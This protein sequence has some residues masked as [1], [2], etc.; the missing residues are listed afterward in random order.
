MYTADHIFLMSVHMLLGVSLLL[1][2]FA[3]RIWSV[4]KDTTIAVYCIYLVVCFIMALV[5]ILNA[6]M[7]VPGSDIMENTWSDELLTAIWGTVYIFFFGWV[8]QFN[9]GGKIKSFFW[10]LA[11][12]VMIFQFFYLLYVRFF[13]E[14]AF[15]DL[16]I[17]MPLFLMITLTSIVVL[18]LAV[19]QKNKTIF[20]K[21]ILAGGVFFYLIALITNIQQ[22]LLKIDDYK[23]F[24]T[25]F[26][27][28]IVENILFAFAIAHRVNTI[29][30]E[31]ERLK[32]NSYRQ[33]LEMEQ[34]TNF[35]ATSISSQYTVDDLLQDVV[36]NCISKLG[37]TNC[38]IYLNDEDRK[39]L[40]QKA[41]VNSETNNEHEISFGKELA[42]IVAQTGKAEIVNISLLDDRYTDRDISRGSEIAV[43][44]ISN[45]RIVGVISS[46]HPQKNFY[47]QHQLQ[48]LSTIA[49]MCTDKMEKIRAEA[50]TR[51]K[52]M[53]VLKLNS[54]LADWQLAALKSQMNPHFL[55]NAMNSIQQFTLKNDSDNANRYIS[56][57]SE[58]LRK[59]LNTSQQKS[60]TIEEEAE[61][62][63]LYL[64][65][66]R[67]RFGKEFTYSVT[68]DSDIEADALKIP[69]MLIQPFAENSIK[70]GLASKEGKKVL[71]I[72]FQL[73]N[74]EQVLVTIADNGIGRRKAMELRQ[75]QKF[76]PHQSKGIE[77]IQE[78][79]QMLKTSG[80]PEVIVFRDLVDDDKQSQGT[81]VEI[82]IPLIFSA[83]VS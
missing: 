68:V 58:L 7:V 33:Q 38:V 6:G 35:F 64:D 59:V 13:S 22:M 81:I 65:I 3:V 79:L 42:G 29:F 19:F 83:P 75:Q 43:P 70:H 76:I 52:E 34:V 25:L 67:L 55:F 48:V 15:F 61:Q 54:D 78:R 4:T 17:W 39:V 37:F 80:D 44:M 50:K 32:V 26:F 53:E 71:H 20:Q 45:G 1:L 9:Q 18:F 14:R 73:K 46:K 5:K 57:F 47:K 51:A 60:I 21:Y 49:S 2:L 56:K 74:E 63:L 23:G 62:L 69:G 72:H 10:K 8:F 27:S 24:N 28:L 11:L 16:V 31:S 12:G 77:L 82:A 66:E 41:P 40:V 36:Q 30:L